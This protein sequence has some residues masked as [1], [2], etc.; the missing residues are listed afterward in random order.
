MNSIT[1][2][3]D[4]VPEPIATLL[5]VYEAHAQALRFPEIDHEALQGL[6]DGVRQAAAE[7][8]RCEQA[9]AQARR[10]L[11]E[12]QRALLARAERGLAYARIYAQDDPALSEQLSELELR[13]RRSAAKRA[14]KKPPRRPARS[15]RRKADA[16]DESVTELPFAG[17]EAEAAVA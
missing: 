16:S 11:D 8:Q 12:H 9:L 2:Q 1:P 6:A 4:P 3:R 5:D 10:S 17:D 13:P 14:G 7:V 15:R